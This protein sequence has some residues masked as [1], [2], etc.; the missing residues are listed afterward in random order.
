LGEIVQL[1]TSFVAL[2]RQTLVLTD[3]R[4]IAH[5]IRQIGA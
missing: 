5:D 4:Q 1:H 3:A 2:H